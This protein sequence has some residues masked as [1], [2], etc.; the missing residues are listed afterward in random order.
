MKRNEVI[1]KGITKNQIWFLLGL[2]FGIALGV[3]V[4]TKMAG[5]LI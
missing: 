2:G 5:G 1:G 4:G 3:L